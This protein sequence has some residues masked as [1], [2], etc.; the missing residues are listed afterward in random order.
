MPDSR[1]SV[2]VQDPDDS[3]A[4]VSDAGDRQ[5]SQHPSQRI[6]S[7]SDDTTQGNPSADEDAESNEYNDS[8][9]M[10]RRMWESRIVATSA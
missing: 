8:E 10:I 7:T 9:M 1:P 3:S 2:Y 5:R 4:N 6:L